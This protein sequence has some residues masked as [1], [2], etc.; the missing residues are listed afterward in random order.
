[1]FTI[2]HPIKDQPLISDFILTIKENFN[3]KSYGTFQKLISTFLYAPR[4]LLQFT[5]QSSL[6]HNE[7][8]K[9]TQ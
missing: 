8:A 2:F 9:S 5:N 6:L 1:M 7:V 3:V 4:Y